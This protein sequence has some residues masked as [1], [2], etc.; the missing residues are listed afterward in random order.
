MDERPDL[1]PR[2]AAEAIGAFTLVFA[3]CGAVG[4]LACRLVRGEHPA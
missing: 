4:A 1:L 2:A 3:G